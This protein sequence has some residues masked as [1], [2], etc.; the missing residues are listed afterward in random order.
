[1]IWGALMSL[2]PNI[3]EILFTVALATM[4]AFSSAVTVQDSKGEFT[5]NYEP[6]RVVVLEFS[7][8]DAL[9]AVGISP[10]GIADD[11]DKDRILPAVQQVIGSWTSVGTRSQPSL[12]VIASLKPDLIIA[13]ISRHEAVYEDLQK[14][15]PTLI[16][17]SRRE[18]YEQNL[19]A[20]V[21]VGTAVG[22][23]AEIEARVALHKQRMSEFAEKLPGNASVQFGVAR[24]DLLSLH[25][26]NAYAGGVLKAL[27]FVNPK[28]SDDGAAYVSTGLEQLLA[29]NPEYLVFGYYT[30]P[31][32]VHKWH[33]EPLW[34]VLQ[35]VQNNH[36]YEVNANTW[37]RA[38]G[39]IA[40]ET[41]AQDLV[42]IF[43]QPE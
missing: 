17:P 28:V 15:A 4:A 6:K 36:V 13:D 27:G 31:S 19:E 16:L 18:T 30:N 8:V 29:I 2:L 40:A 21:V 34:S 22:K 37:S 3:R 41:M 1:M 12:E 24:D 32:I 10:V 7:F 38:R 25:S 5:L 39:M 26:A 20:A 33:D 14:I 42:R 9:A 43:A 11:K 35:A 23:K